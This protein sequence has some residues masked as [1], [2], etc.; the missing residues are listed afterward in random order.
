MGAG[1]HALT[2]S[3]RDTTVT[4][5]TLKVGQPSWGY[6]FV[7]V[8]TIYFLGLSFIL[9]RFFNQEIFPNINKRKFGFLNEL[10]KDK[11]YLR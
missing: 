5:N 4:K 8:N 9:I 1:S 6:L 2:H 3:A 7:N 11:N 10:Y